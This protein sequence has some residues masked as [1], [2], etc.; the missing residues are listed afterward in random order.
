MN[1]IPADI[2]KLF[3]DAQ[4]IY[5]NTYLILRAIDELGLEKTL[6]DL[7]ANCNYGIREE[8]SEKTYKGFLLLMGIYDESL[9]KSNAPKGEKIKWNVV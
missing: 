9:K 3:E 1:D 7:R 8:P 2:M 6:E 5:L 4:S